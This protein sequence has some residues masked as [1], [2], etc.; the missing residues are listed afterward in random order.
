MEKKKSRS[1]Q[2]PFTLDA[3][4]EKKLDELCNSYQISRAEAI[5]RSILAMKTNEEV[6]TFNFFLNNIEKTYKEVLET[7]ETITKKENVKEFYEK[8]DEI[9]KAP[10]LEEYPEINKVFYWEVDSGESVVDFME[11]TLKISNVF[12]LI[13]T[14]NSI[15]SE[16]VKGEWQAAYQ[17]RKRGKM[18]IVP[19]FEKEDDVPLLLLPLLNVEFTK[20]DFDGFIEKL[21]KEIIRK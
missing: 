18:K 11:E 19:V 10:E 8:F 2:F 6:D 9:N 3:Q 15:K 7:M 13:C 21:Y 4:T 16:A 1:K 20:D 14:E 12:V 17:L 5:R